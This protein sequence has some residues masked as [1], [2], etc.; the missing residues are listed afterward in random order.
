[1]FSSEFNGFAQFLA[2]L[3]GLP[4]PV[5]IAL[6]FAIGIGWI[7]WRTRSTH[8]VIRHIW[9]LVF[10]RAAFADR[11]IA[12]F[13]ETRNRL[14][15]FRFIAGLPVRTLAQAKRLLRWSTVNDEELATV[16][17][18]G[19]LFDL[20]NCCL[21]DEQIPSR[22]QQVLLVLLA[23]IFGFAVA[24]FALGS[25]TDRAVLQ[26]KESKTWF[27]LSTKAAVSYPGNGR[28]T[29]KACADATGKQMT[30]QAFTADEATIICKALGD[31]NIK[32]DIEQIV[33]QQR[34]AFGLV[35]VFLAYC[36]STCWAT[37]R[38]SYFARSMKQRLSS[39]KQITNTNQE[40]KA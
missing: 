13:I 27:L 9:R 12:R 35:G 38:R 34:L 40:N 22:W 15:T 37:F 19:D 17:A 29:Q 28:I 6:A 14:V 1:M 26:F 21:R 11:E 20:E 2:D 16:K 7:C 30:S 36:A 24:L 4:Q 23:F 10:G 33:M 5:L 25:L 31:V 32:D 8:V 3:L 39:K 18:C